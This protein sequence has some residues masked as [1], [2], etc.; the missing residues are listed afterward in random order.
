MH[1]WLLTAH[2]AAFLADTDAWSDMA[3]TLRNTSDGTSHVATGVSF[4]KIPDKA[5]AAQGQMVTW[6]LWAADIQSLSM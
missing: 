6:V 2:N 3:V 5:Y 4:G 1:K